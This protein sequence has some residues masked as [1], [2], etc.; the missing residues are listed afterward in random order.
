MVLGYVPHAA[1]RRFYG[2]LLSTKAE[3]DLEMWVKDYLA[4]CRAKGLSP[5]TIHDNYGHALTKHWL[6]WCQTQ[7]ITEVGQINN[8]VLDRFSADLQDKPSR[9]GRKLAERSVSTYTEAVNYWLGWLAKEREVPVGM[10]AHA[11]KPPRKLLA[12]LTRAEIQRMEDVAR[13]ERDKLI[14]RTLADTGL[15]LGELLGL[16]DSDLM[17]VGRQRFLR[18]MGKGRKQR[19]VAVEQTTFRRLERLVRSRPVTADTDH[20][21]VGVRARPGGGY[22][23][24]TRSGAEHMIRNLAE[25]AGVEKRVYP[26]LF[27]HTYATWAL[28]RGVNPIALAKHLGH[29]GLA[30][31]QRTYGHQTDADIHDVMLR[32]LKED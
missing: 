13:Y 18:V 5:R 29:E 31:I 14:V 10:K 6:P 19:D 28:N 11:P 20:L 15:R 16:R 12:V 9:T 4:H 7:G 3:Q 23:V 30:M 32:L 22:A 17:M 21:F 8:R 25:M 2:C 26:H 1:P 24:I 27:R